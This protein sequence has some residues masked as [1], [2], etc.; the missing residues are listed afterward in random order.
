MVLCAVCFQNVQ[1]AQEDITC[2][3]LYVEGDLFSK[4]TERQTR[5]TGKNRRTVVG[6]VQRVL[7]LCDSHSLGGMCVVDGTPGRGS[8]TPIHPRVDEEGRILLLGMIA[9]GDKCRT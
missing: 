3:F 2:V 7:C 6:A 5:R 8:R 1:Q 4:R 9:L